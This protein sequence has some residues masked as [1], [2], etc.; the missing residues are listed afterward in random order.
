MV[1]VA[2]YRP[3]EGA[4]AE[5]IS[6]LVQAALLPHTLPGWTA[7]AVAHL[8]SENS[9]QAL[10]ERFTEAAFTR[11]CVNEG[12]IV[13]FIQCK[14]SRLL[15]LLAVHPSLQRSG[16]GSQLLQCM[17]VHVADAAPDISV[18]EVNATEYSLPFY[19]RRGFYPLSEF[20][21]HEGCRFVRL[22]YWRKNPLLG[23]A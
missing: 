11:V 23:A 22:G 18:V 19:R 2:S 10:R 6:D 4:D 21:E 15:G 7:D 8:Y 3:A 16:I 14:R 20:I 12:V 5:S 9:P 1:V 17:L 13:G